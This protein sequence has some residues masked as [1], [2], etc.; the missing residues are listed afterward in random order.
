MAEISFS[1][2]DGGHKGKVEQRTR[3]GAECGL[4]KDRIWLEHRKNFPKARV[5]KRLGRLPL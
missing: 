4:D 5:Q 3:K 2:F 1:S